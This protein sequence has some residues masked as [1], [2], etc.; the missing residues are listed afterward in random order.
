MLLSGFL[1]KVLDTALETSI[2][3]GIIFLFKR[4]FRLK[5]GPKILD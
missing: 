2:L 3:Y 4:R 5:V 1:F